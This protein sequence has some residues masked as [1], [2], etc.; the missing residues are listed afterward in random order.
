MRITLRYGQEGLSVELPEDNVAHVLRLNEVPALGD[1]LLATHAACAN[2]LSSPA[3]S[4]LALG[5]ENACIVIPDITRPI[6]NRILLPPILQTLRATGLDPDSILILVATGLHRPATE[7]ELAEMLGE[8]IIAGGYHIESHVAR[9]RAGHVHLGRT[10]RGTEVWIDRRYVDADL[11]ILVSL[12][13]PHVHAGYS[14][15]RKTICPGLSAAET[16]MGF[17]RP[18]LIEDPTAIAGNIADN[19]TDQETHEV[20]ALAGRADFTINCTLNEQREVTGI[21]AGEF[22][23][24]PLAAMELAERQSKVIIPAPV[25]IAITTNAGYPVDLSFYQS[26]KGVSAA[27]AIVKPG[28]TIIMAQEN[29]EGIGGPEFTELILGLKDPHEF[30]QRVLRT[31]ETQIDQWTVHQLEK[32]LRH[33]KI[34]NYCSGIPADLQKELF[35]EPISSVEEGVQ[36]ALADHGPQATIA[37]IPEGP[38]V[39]PCLSDDLLGR[40]NVRQMAKQA[41][42]ELR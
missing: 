15:G 3:L 7:D 24:A 13:E 14:G 34:Y 11:R 39:L 27:V 4:E 10:S 19:A 35:V 20:A 32:N 21:F 26:Q 17:H 28:G 22:F 16:I 5:R 38:F 6:P 23:A 40:M 42:H 30:I 33:H 12:V 25:D 1:P 36:R 29:A 37:V 8:Q 2:P 18:A 9:D 41:G 31:G